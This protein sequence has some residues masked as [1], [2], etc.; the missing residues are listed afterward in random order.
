MYF[1]PDNESES[2]FQSRKPNP[3]ESI[4]NLHIGLSK[5]L[6]SFH[7]V[8]E[9]GGLDW[10]LF[11]YAGKK[12]NV[13]MKFTIAFVIGDTELH[14]KLCG[15][16]GVRNDKVKRLCCHCDCPTSEI[17]NPKNKKQQKYIYHPT[18]ILK[19]KRAA[20]LFSIDITLSHQ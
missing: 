12:W 7:E 17:T 16:Y 9:A 8:N 18:L 19:R 2:V 4:Q 14:D 13:R 6:E 10:D 11:P 5:A 20:W 15:Q 1:H 3:K